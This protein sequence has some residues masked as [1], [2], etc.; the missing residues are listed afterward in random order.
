M[1]RSLWRVFSIAVL[2]VIPVLGIAEVARSASGKS[3]NL[4]SPGFSTWPPESSLGPSICTKLPKFLAFTSQSPSSAEVMQIIQLL[5]DVKTS[6]DTCRLNDA[7][8]TLQSFGPPVLGFLKPLLKD[9]DPKVRARTMWVLG[10][11][12]FGLDELSPDRESAQDDEWQ[13]L[14]GLLMPLLKDSDI[15]VR[16][17][18]IRAIGA[19]NR[20]AV[21]AVTLLGALL[22]DPDSSI[23]ADTALALGNLG[24]T[25]TGTFPLLRLR[26]QDPDPNVRANVAWAIGAITQPSMIP[27]SKYKLA[28]S[29]IQ[30]RVASLIAMLQDPNSTVRANAAAALCWM[31]AFAQPAMPSLI[32]LLRDL[33]PNVRANAARAIGESG[34]SAQ[35][36]LASLIPQLEDPDP[37]VRA[38]TAWAIGKIGKPAKSAALYLILKL[39]DP[40]RHVRETVLY[41]LEQIGESE[42]LELPVLIELLNDPN[43][44]VQ[45]NAATMIGNRGESAKTAIPVL[46]PLLSATGR[47]EF[48]ANRASRAIGRIGPTAIPFLTPLLGKSNDKWVRVRAIY[49]LGEMGEA[50]NPTISRLKLLTVDLDG[51]VRS[52]ATKALM[53][54][55]DDRSKSPLS[56]D[57]RTT[58]IP[59]LLTLPWPDPSPP[60]PYP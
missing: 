40:D 49:A 28:E 39:S 35:P 32:P 54:M 44:F 18:T 14:T 53:E 29:S 7:S 12:S 59:E 16:L 37:N 9:A 52:A 15:R 57:D 23:R 26:L 41:A 47:R 11:F 8:A 56:V 6:D 19:I 31:D 24:G 1:A 33:D 48:V 38:S 58:P 20:R 3:E 46:I 5:R 27:G 50:A 43:P 4:S 13:E 30:N 60:S 17:Y 22:E 36:A 55:A 51:A 21:P 34:E 45:G 25:A 2:S 42:R 10:G